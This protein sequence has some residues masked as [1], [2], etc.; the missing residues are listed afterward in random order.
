MIVMNVCGTHC[1]RLR[2]PAQGTFF[3]VIR[4]V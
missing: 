3:M 4:I 2:N 1:R